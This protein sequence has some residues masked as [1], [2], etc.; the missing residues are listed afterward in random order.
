MGQRLQLPLVLVLTLL[1]PHWNYL[2]KLY[3]V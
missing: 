3:L 2:S 1:L